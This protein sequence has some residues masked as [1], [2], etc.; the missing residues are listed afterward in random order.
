MGISTP[1]V[2]YA[3]YLFLGKNLSSTIKFFINICTKL[4]ELP[5]GR[6]SVNAFVTKPST[7]LAPHFLLVTYGAKSHCLSMRYMLSTNV[8]MDGTN[9]VG[10]LRSLPFSESVVS[11]LDKVKENLFPSSLPD[12]M[13]QLQVCRSKSF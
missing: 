1:Y 4:D 13:D 5:S 7:N 9:V 10:V 2:V 12:Q 8:A 6:Y 3:F 11:D